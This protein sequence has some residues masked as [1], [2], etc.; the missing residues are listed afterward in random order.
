M[1]KSRRDYNKYWRTPVSQQ[2]KQA[3]KLLSKP[4]VLSYSTKRRT[5][6]YYKASRKETHVKVE[7]MIMDGYGMKKI[8]ESLRG[9]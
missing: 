6:A 4:S 2:Y 7:K 9:K 3:R 8:L 1:S 5:L